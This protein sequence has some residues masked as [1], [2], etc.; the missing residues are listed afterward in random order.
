MSEV[1]VCYLCTY[2]GYIIITYLMTMY[3]YPMVKDAFFLE[4]PKV[5]MTKK[6]P[7]EQQAARAHTYAY[8]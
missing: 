6:S 4:I 7:S 2:N 1:G 5:C 3:T 8:R